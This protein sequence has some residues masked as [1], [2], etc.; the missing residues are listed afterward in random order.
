MSI[1]KPIMKTLLIQPQPMSPDMNS[2]IPEVTQLPETQ[3]CK[4]AVSANSV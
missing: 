3:N 4:P 2:L 1:P